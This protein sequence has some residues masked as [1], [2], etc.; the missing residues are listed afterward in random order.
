MRVRAVD[1]PD[2]VSNA[3][4]QTGLCKTDDHRLRMM[5]VLLS[6]SFLKVAS[7]G[8]SDWVINRTDEVFK[9][10]RATC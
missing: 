5:N 7:S 9:R 10:E 2:D 3:F 1:V 6:S 8:F 4:M